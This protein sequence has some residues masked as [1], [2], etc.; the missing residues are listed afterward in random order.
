[1]AAEHRV[2]S[3]QS[4]VTHGY[5][6]NRSAVLPLQLAGLEVDAINVVNFS[7][8][9]GYSRWGGEK[10]SVDAFE[11][12]W[13][14]LKQ[15]NLCDYTHLLTGYI[16]GAAVLQAVSDSI[17]QLRASNPDFIYLLDPVMGDDGKL[18]VSDEVIPIY[19]AIL[20]K[21]TCATPNH[22]EA[23]VLTGIK[24]VDLHT[25]RQALDAFHDQ[26]HLPHI[27]ISSVPLPV[28]ALPDVASNGNTEWLV[29][30]GSTCCADQDTKR[31][32]IPFEKLD[33]HYE[34]VGDLFSALM[35]SRL[36]NV[37]QA[38]PV[39]CEVSPLAFAARRSIEQLQGI[40]RATQRYALQRVG[41]DASRLLASSNETI[42]HRIRRLRAVELRLVQN[43]DILKG[44]SGT[45]ALTAYLL[46]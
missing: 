40:I 17:D 5:V 15:N 41:G 1:M 44:T 45:A 43:Q 39:D 36:A 12:I 24:I 4:H 27:V 10:I 6:G 30:A 11:D 31:F 25:L 42:E 33:E 20:P 22:F 28:S 21:A 38:K 13:T 19:K 16:P 7:N 9:T 34:G 3:I 26:Y 14:S 46:W 35:L 32:M 2:L 23:E 18:Y 8:H 29:C 37:V